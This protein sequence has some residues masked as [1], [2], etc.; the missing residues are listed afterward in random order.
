MAWQLFKAASICSIT[1]STYRKQEGMQGVMRRCFDGRRDSREDN[2][3]EV[4]FKYA[5]FA[6]LT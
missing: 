3:Y 4:A 5:V 2:V 6:R 1:R